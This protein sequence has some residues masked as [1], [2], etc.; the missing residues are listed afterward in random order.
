MTGPT[1]VEEATEKALE[2]ILSD[3]RNILH[4]QRQMNGKKYTIR[5]VKANR[6]CC[7][8][9]KNYTSSSELREAMSNPRSKLMKTALDEMALSA[10]VLWRCRS[11]WSEKA[12]AKR[13]E[14]ITFDPCIT[15]VAD[16]V[17]QVMDQKWWDYQKE[18]T[19]GVERI[20][21]E[22][23]KQE[24]IQTSQEGEALVSQEQTRKRK[25]KRSLS[26]IVNPATSEKSTMTRSNGGKKRRKQAEDQKEVKIAS[27][28]A[29]DGEGKDEEHTVSHEKPPQN[30]W[31]QSLDDKQPQQ[32]N[33]AIPALETYDAPSQEHAS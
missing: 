5:F 1:F 30:G 23:N 26:V 20:Q 4:C 29:K 18:K 21:E 8:E 10:D 32:E 15:R 28:I 19:N 31:E 13:S 22:S 17:P 33:E 16:D 14:L 12:L 9:W 11:Q 3:M 7:Q 6:S 24:D 25:R 27:P 2:S